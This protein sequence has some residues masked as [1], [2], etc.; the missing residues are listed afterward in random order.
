[1]PK[2][3]RGRGLRFS[4]PELFRIALTLMTLLGVILLARPCATSVSGFVM[5]MDGSG[6]AARNAMP[7]PGTVDQPQQ[8][9]QLKPDMT[10][11]E[12]KE[13]IE[14]SKARG[15]TVPAPGAPEPGSAAPTP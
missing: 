15:G 5:D 2:L 10:E 3:P 9:E 8:F 11:A 4:G 7:K 14:R 1:M 12:L 13:A 6:S